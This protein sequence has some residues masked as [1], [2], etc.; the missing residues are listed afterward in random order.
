MNQTKKIFDQFIC[1]WKCFLSLLVS[2]FCTYFVFQCFKLV[3]VLKNR[4]QSLSWVVCDLATSRKAEKC[5]FGH[6]AVGFT[7]SSWVT[8]KLATREMPRSTISWVFHELLV[9]NF[10]YDSVMTPS[11]P[12]PLCQS[13][14]IKIKL[15][16]IVLYSINISKVIF[17]TFNWL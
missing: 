2:R 6:Q 1:N 11:S 3:F 10:S 17:N 7:S 5:I 16:S 9:Q 14:Y 4:G 12:S 15:L 13:F 8:R